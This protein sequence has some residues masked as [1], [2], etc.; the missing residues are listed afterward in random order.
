MESEPN[1]YEKVSQILNVFSVVKNPFDFISEKV[2][3]EPYQ[4]L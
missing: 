4:H 2:G 1:S 3:S